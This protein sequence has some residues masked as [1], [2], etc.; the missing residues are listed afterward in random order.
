MSAE[1]KKKKSAKS[2]AEQASEVE[3]SQVTL[4]TLSPAHGSTHRKKRLGC[5]EGSGHGKTS[6]RGGKGQTARSGYSRKLGFEG[7]QVPLYR[8]LPKV[9]FTSRKK[10][11]GENVFTTLSLA[12]LSALVDQA[13]LGS[14]VTLQALIEHGV[15]RSK[16]H[17][18]K[19]LGGSEFNKKLVVEVHAISGSARAAIEGA[20]GEV[21]LIS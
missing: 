18:V 6:G 12:R 21:R 9:G 3:V 13:N 5:G 8:R 2:S 4:S 14:E 15:V 10:V 1:T 16:R 19:L 11:L 20:G 7:G 17:K